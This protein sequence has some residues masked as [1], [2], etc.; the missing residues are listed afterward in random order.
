M[1]KKFT[2]VREGLGRQVARLRE[3]A[4]M[5]HQALADAAGIARQTVRF[6]EAHPTPYGTSLETMLK[7]C[8]AL[9]AEPCEVVSRLPEVKLP[10]STGGDTLPNEASPT[11]GKKASGRGNK[12]SKG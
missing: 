10:P 11:T 9:G 5:T 12:G 6:L 4:G 3:A 8:K 2:G 1:G 7:L